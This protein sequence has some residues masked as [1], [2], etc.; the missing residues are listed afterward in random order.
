Q[1]FLTVAPT[2]FLDGKHSVFGEIVEGLDVAI[3]ISN[4]PRDS[5]DRPR[6]DVK[7]TKVTIVR[8]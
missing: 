2:P 6:E 8:E 4:V 5:N 7:I 1:F 3:A